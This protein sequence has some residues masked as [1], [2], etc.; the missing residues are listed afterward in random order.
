MTRIAIV[1]TVKIIIN[2]IAIHFHQAASLL[3]MLTHAHYFYG[4]SYNSDRS[5]ISIIVATEII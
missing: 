1:T 4:D 5:K 2:K 3:Q